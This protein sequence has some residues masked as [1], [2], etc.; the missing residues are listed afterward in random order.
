MKLYTLKRSFTTGE[1]SPLLKL[2]KDLKR[3]ANGC[4]TLLNMILTP[5]GPTTRRPGTVYISDLTY[6]TDQ[7]GMGT[8]TSYRAIPFIFDKD[9]AYAL[10]FVSDGTIDR[11]YFGYTNPTTGEDG[12][13]AHPSPSYTGEP[14]NIT[15]NAAFNFDCD[16]FDWAQEKDYLYMA[17][18]G[19][20]TLTLI[21]AGH[22]SWSVA[23]GGFTY[24]TSPTTWS[25]GNGFPE[26]VSFYQQ[27][28][29]L[30]ATDASPQALWLSETGNYLNFLPS[31]TLVATS[32]LA[33]VLASGEHNKIQWVMGARRLF[34]GTLGDEYVITGGSDP[35]A[36]DTVRADSHSN[37]GSFPIKPIKVGSNVL[38]VENLGRNVNRL[39]YDYQ[40]DSFLA[41]S[42]SALAPHLLID[43][44]IKNW[45][46]QKTPHNIIWCKTDSDYMLGVTYNKQHG[47]IGWHRHTTQGTWG[48]ICCIPDKYNR[49]TATWMINERSIDGSTK[50]YVEKMYKTYLYDDND[51]NFMYL[52]CAKYIDAPGSATITGL[53]HLEG[54]TVDIIA[55]G[56][57]H[58]P[59][60]VS[61]GEI[62]LYKEYDE[63]WVGFGYDSTIIPTESSPQINDGESEGRLRRVQKII[64][65]LYKS[66]GFSYGKD[67]SSLESYPPRR[68]SHPTGVGVPP[69]S[70]SIMVDF[71]S[72]FTRDPVVIIK[73]EKPLPLTVLGLTELYEITEEVR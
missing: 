56:G 8:I 53:D 55:D 72:G 30:S 29:I 9:T 10:L 61:S 27:R 21:R 43:K 64:V 73:Q 65:N 17:Y 3:Y 5:Q 46:H 11:I 33:L 19:N 15:I 47:I 23:A 14:Y 25:A 16:N 70:S 71:P 54:E 36:Y 57:Y 13:I 62:E 45:A 32:P 48:D 42:I 1:V 52:D 66:V 40:T 58:A 49:Q 4:L 35:I 20:E 38:F 24:P 59:Q 69:T 22:T 44:A 51:T 28:L 39:E 50:L 34:A 18:S 41:N 12:L 6:H 67:E 60:V 37:Q 31:G 26:R 7:G 63:V 2:R 68:V